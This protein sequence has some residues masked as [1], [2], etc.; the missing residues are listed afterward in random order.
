MTPYIVIRYSKIDTYIFFSFRQD[1]FHTANNQVVTYLSDTRVTIRSKV[2]LDIRYVYSFEN[3]S[4][5][6]GISFN[7]YT[8]GLYFEQ[9]FDSEHEANRNI[10]SLLSNMHKPM[11]VHFDGSYDIKK[12][13]EDYHIFKYSN[14]ENKNLIY[15]RVLGWCAQK[16]T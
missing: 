3:Q 6:H 9:E 4:A 11:S 10:A 14:E 16:T 5:K 2:A 15:E 13:G 1:P 12:V 7:A 8:P